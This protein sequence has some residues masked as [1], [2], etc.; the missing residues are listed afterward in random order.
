ME[1]LHR[2]DLEILSNFSDKT[3]EGEFANKELGG[4]L[5]ASDFTES[6]SSGPET[7]G[8]LDTT[9]CVLFIGESVTSGWLMKTIAY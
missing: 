4:L 1:S 8:L 2:T 5:V 7:M 3:L 9:G 6:D